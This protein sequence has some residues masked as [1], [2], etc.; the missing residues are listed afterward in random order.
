MLVTAIRGHGP[1]GRTLRH[2]YP[3]MLLPTQPV[4]THAAGAPV[5]LLTYVDPWEM[6]AACALRPWTQT[7]VN[8]LGGNSARF[9]RELERTCAGK[10][11]LI[12]RGRTSQNVH[13]AAEEFVDCRPNKLQGF[14]ALQATLT[15]LRPRT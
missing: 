5:Y 15:T 6:I 7:V 13:V 2:S 4:T 1:D 11:E 10:H 12:Y 9:G 8:G 3:L 14:G